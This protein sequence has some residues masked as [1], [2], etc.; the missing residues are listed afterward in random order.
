MVFGVLTRVMRKAGS[1]TPLG[2]FSSKRGNKN[3]YKGKG[4]KK[5]GK[6]DKWARFQLR[7]FPNYYVPDMTGFQVR[8]PSNLCSSPIP[9]RHVVRTAAQAICYSN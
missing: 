3:F 7:G 8:T 9:L 1:H 6:P 2:N 4:G 5:Y